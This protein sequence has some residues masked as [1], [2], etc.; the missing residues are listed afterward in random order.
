MTEIIYSAQRSGFESGRVYENPR[1]F[2]SVNP[3]ATSVVVIGDWPDVV[4]AYEAKKIPVKTDF[5][6]APKKS[7]KQEEPVDPDTD[8]DADDDGDGDGDTPELNLSPEWKKSSFKTLQR[9]VKKLDADK[10]V[11]DRQEAI[12]FIEA[13]LPPAE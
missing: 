8:D 11:K 3:H 13:H 9:H 2:R 10:K 5:M 6:K 4:A 7:V 12:E 1:F